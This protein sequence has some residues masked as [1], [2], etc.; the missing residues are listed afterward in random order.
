[1]RKRVLIVE[2]DPGT[3]QLLGA[4]LS[5]FDV[6]IHE[7]SRDDEGYQRFLEVGPD[8]VFLDVLLPR[9]GGLELLRRI[10][11][12]R[13]GKEVPVFVMS[14][15]YRGAD[16]RTEAVDELG[17]VDFLKKPFQLDVLQ[18]RIAQV[19][20]DGT[21]EAPEAGIKCDSPI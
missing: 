12:V 6:D 5:D 11:G 2:D 13:G 14:A 10:R 4:I 1:M 7:A 15:V 17:A 21:A 20:A 8:L 16:I 3:R 19:L 9:R 18:Q